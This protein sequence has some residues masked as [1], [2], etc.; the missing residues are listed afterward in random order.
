MSLSIPIEVLLAVA[1]RSHEPPEKLDDNDDDG[2]DDDSPLTRRRQHNDTTPM[3]MI[4]TM[5]KWGEAQTGPV[6]DK[7]MQMQTNTTLHEQ[8]NTQF[9]TKT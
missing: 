4:V 8:H 3:T 1:A 7:S 6:K 5:F 9:D 2:G